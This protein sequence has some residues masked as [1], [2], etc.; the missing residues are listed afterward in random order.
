MSRKLCLLDVGHSTEAKLSVAVFGITG[1]ES[2]RWEIENVVEAVRFGA[3]RIGNLRLIVLGRNTQSA[4]AELTNRF[5]DSPVELHVL[6]VLPGEDVVRSLSVSDV[7]LFVRGHISTRRGSA[8]AGIACG[9]PVI[10]FEGSETAAPITEAGLAFFSPQRKGDLG[11]VLLRVLEDEP[12]RTSLA[13][14]SLLAQRQYFSWR[15]IA[16]RYA[17][18]LRRQR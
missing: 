10:A 12:Y 9:L 5:R 18:F 4:E 13:Q 8:I 14:R 1:G 2:G 16:A 11:D 15:V 3:S 7:L 17:E 6:G